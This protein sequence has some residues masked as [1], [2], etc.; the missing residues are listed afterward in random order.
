MVTGLVVRRRP[1]PRTAKVARGETTDRAPVS[2]RCRREPRAGRR[3][4][5]AFEEDGEPDRALKQRPHRKQFQE[6]RHRVGPGEREGDDRD[7]EVPDAA[8]LA[9]RP[10]AEYAQADEPEYQ[11]GKLKDDHD[12]Q[13]HGGDERVIRAR[14]DEVEKDRAV[15]VRQPTHCARED[16]PITEGETSGAES[17]RNGDEAEHLSLHPSF[18]G[19]GEKGPDLPEDHGRCEHDS[20]VQADGQRDR[21]RLGDAECDQAPMAGRQWLLEPSEEARMEGV[22]DDGR[23]GKRPDH[24]EEPSPQLVQMLCERRLFAVG[25]AARQP[26]HREASRT[27]GRSAAKR[28]QSVV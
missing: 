23:D 22:G 27:R 11:E 21:E 28:V 4:P 13:Q 7:D 20:G 1:H 14:L 16:D 10:R 19:G 26:A 6:G 15:V 24:D 5:P 18:E 3:A 25:K 9:Q 12:P 8:V 2:G 17:H